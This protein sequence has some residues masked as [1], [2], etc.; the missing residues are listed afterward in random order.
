MEG[1]K[2]LELATLRVLFAKKKKEKKKKNSWIEKMASQEIMWKVSWRVILSREWYNLLK[3]T[4]IC[5]LF[6]REKSRY[7][8]IDFHACNNFKAEEKGIFYICTKRGV[9]SLFLK[10]KK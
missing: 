8:A 5:P 1:W 9:I 4:A 7:L 3:P 6:P 10:K 2:Q